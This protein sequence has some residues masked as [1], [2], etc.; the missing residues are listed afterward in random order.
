[1]KR[2]T[3]DQ[4]QRRLDHFRTREQQLKGP[5]EGLDLEYQ[6]GRIA[7]LAGVKRSLFFG[8]ATSID[9]GFRPKQKLHLFQ[10]L[11]KMEENVRWRGINYYEMD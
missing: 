10:L 8:A 9:H 6:L 5:I 3:E 4:L 7:A 2:T 11:N 1:V